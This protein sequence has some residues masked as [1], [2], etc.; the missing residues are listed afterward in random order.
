MYFILEKNFDCLFL[1][2][3]FSV[4]VGVKLEKNLDKVDFCMILYNFI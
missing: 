2:R 4:K 1:N 3:M